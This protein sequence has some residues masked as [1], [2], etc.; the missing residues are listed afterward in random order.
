MVPARTHICKMEYRRNGRSPRS[1]LPSCLVFITESAV[2]IQRSGL[3]TVNSEVMQMMQT[4]FARLP[5]R[6]RFAQ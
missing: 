2:A 4:A 5:A 1:L 3:L 6:T